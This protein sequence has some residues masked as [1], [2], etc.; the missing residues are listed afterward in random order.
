[1]TL[2]E[3]LTQKLLECD[4]YKE[5]TLIDAGWYFPKNNFQLEIQDQGVLF[6]HL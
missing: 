2:D 6:L 5:T 4:N 1:M 3:E